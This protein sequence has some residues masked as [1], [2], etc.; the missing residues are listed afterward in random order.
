MI[1]DRRAALAQPSLHRFVPGMGYMK[2]TPRPHGRQAGGSCTP[3]RAAANASLHLLLPPNGAEPVKMIWNQR[4]QSWS[5]EHMMAGNRMAW[6]A[7]YL[8]SHGWS[9]IG[10]A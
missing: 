4:D 3:P 8:A 6:T 10:P 9:Y 5:A 7:L 1:S 2:V